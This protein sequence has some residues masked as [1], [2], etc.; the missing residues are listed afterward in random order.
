MPRVIAIGDV[1]AGDRV[2]LKGSLP[3][4]KLSI[5]V[6]GKMNLGRL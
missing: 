5:A 1:I 3:D 2:I 6:I 4:L